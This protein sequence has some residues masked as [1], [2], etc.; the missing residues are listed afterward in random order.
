MGVPAP[1]ELCESEVPLTQILLGA[2]TVG[3]GVKG[4]LSVRARC[5]LG[6][7]LLCGVCGVWAVAVEHALE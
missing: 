5:L 4:W 7:D 1:C 2:C 3:H 6:V